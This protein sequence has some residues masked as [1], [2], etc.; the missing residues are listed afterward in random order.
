MKNE[1]QRQLAGLGDIGLTEAE[2]FIR[3][4]RAAHVETRN[5]T[6]PDDVWLTAFEGH[7]SQ[8]TR[9]HAQQLEEAGTHKIVGAPTG[10]DATDLVWVAT[11]KGAV[12]QAPKQAAIER[13]DAGT[14]RLAKPEEYG[15]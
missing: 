11:T 12:V 3:E 2:D 9:E 8:T 5:A 13:L 1:L 14:H 10:N 15:A 6:L 4:L 7:R